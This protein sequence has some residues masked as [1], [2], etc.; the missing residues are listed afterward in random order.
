MKIRRL[1]R[2]FG[3]ATTV[4]T[5]AATLALAYGGGVSLAANVVASYQAIPTKNTGQFPCQDSSNGTPINPTEIHCYG[6][7]QIRAAYHIQPLL[8]AGRDGR[9]ETIAI[10][11]SFSEPNITSDLAA[12]DSNYGIPAPPS[13]KIVAPFGTT[14][15][16]VNDP[17]QV[18]WS[19]EIAIDVE[20]AHAI[21]PGANI[22]LA[23]APS[24]SD[25]DQINTEKYVVQHKLANVVSMSFSE[26]EQCMAPTLASAEHSAYS[27]ATADGVTFVAAA[28]DFGAAQPSNCAGTCPCTL[29]AGIPASDPFVTGVGGT[30]LKADLTTGSY[31][32]ETVAN[33]PGGAGGGGFSV[34]YGKPSFQTGA[35]AGSARGVPDVT[36]SASEQHSTLVKWSTSGTHFTWW[37]FAGTS[38][39]TP[40][41][42]AI[43][44]IADQAAGRGLGNVNPALYSLPAADFHDIKTGDNSFEGVTGFKAMQGWDA[45]SGLGSPIADLVVAGLCGCRP[46]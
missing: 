5:M 36:Y 35:V 4:A 43:F 18:G 9:S 34:L 44:A 37:G 2:P 14:P 30:D 8:D 3:L 13:F 45:A 10:I 24:D 6:P 25:P 41:W 38:L 42:A 39:G 33:E 32:N 29:S 19:S 26:A 31:Q 16:N 20:W 12:F 40:Q 11:D 27:T 1:T 28:G 46:T 23:L 22:V 17:N 15:F 21:A 7:A